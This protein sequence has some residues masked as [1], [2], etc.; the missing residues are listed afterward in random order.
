MFAWEPC[1][2]NHLWTACVPGR[3]LG[4]RD[5]AGG[6][7][8]PGTYDALANMLFAPLPTPGSSGGPIVDEQTGAV[9]GVIR[10][11]RMDSAV[12]GLR[13]WAVPA[14]AIYEVRAPIFSFNENDQFFSLLC[15]GF[16]CLRSA[17][18][19]L[20]CSVGLTD[21]SSACLR[22]G[23]CC[24]QCAPANHERDIRHLIVI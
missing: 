4:Y 18:L 21:R 8:H 15:F 24:K 20:P 16:G 6:E 13:G 17:P 5:W 23:V 10:G 12:E 19:P 2:A 14:E 1:F 9:V 22:H 7:A 11:T 3:V